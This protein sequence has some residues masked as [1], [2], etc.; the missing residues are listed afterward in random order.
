MKDNHPDNTTNKNIDSRKIFCQN[1][2]TIVGDQSR[3]GNKNNLPV[4]L[5]EI[6]HLGGKQKKAIHPIQIGYRENKPPQAI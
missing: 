2:E 3:K 6:S 5:H 1:D 4:V